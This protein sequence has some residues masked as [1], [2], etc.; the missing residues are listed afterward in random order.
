MMVLNQLPAEFGR[1]SLDS[2]IDQLLTDAIGAGDKYAPSWR[3]VYNLFEDNE[4]LTIQLAL[5]GMEANQIDVQ[6]V[7][8]ELHVKGEKP[9]DATQ[10]RSWLVRTIPEGRFVWSCQLPD[11][12]DSER[13]KASYTQGL[14]TLHFAKREES[15]PRKIAITCK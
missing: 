9:A 11:S 6:V 10:A 1:R 14:L 5:P 15:K 12:V 13:G 2:Q 7:N 4:G 3:P 8:N